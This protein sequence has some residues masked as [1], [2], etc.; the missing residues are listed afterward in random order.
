MAGTHLNGSTQ[1]Y[2]DG[3]H[4]LDA[5]GSRLL[6][7]NRREHGARITNFFSTEIKL[8]EVR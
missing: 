7:M 4:Q 3:L 2:G 5:A 6:L 1:L 8:R